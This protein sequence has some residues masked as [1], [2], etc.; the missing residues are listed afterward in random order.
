MKITGDRATVFL[1][2]LRC[3]FSGRV[4]PLSLMS[5]P[6]EPL[7]VV[8]VHVRYGGKPEMAVVLPT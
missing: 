7:T 4:N 3:L 1:Y 6:G 2:L 5:Y 8:V